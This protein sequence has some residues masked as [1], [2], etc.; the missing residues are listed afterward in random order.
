MFIPKSHKFWIFSLLFEI[1][2]SNLTLALSQLITF[3]T[4]AF[5]IFLLVKVFRRMN[6]FFQSFNLHFILAYIFFSK[7]SFFC[8][9]IFI[10][11]IIHY[12]SKT[13]ILT[14]NNLVQF[15][16]IYTIRIQNK[17][18]IIFMNVFFRI[19]QSLFLNISFKKCFTFH[20]RFV[21]LSFLVRK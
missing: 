18:S 12:S 14:I 5:N 4:I 8:L 11:H 3:M 15:K 9:L 2:S 10:F 1:K 19:S 21:W 16:F 17:K 20:N 13:E 6:Q 7:C